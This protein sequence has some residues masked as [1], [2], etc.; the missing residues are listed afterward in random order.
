MVIMAVLQNLILS[1]IAAVAFGIMFNVPTHCLKYCAILGASACF[2]RTILFYLGA[3]AWL[4]TFFPA[5]LVGILAI[6]FSEKFKAHPKVVSVAAVI[7]MFPGVSA[8]TAMIALIEIIDTGYTP[9]LMAK[10]VTHFLHASS[11]VCALSL[12]LTLPSIWMYRKRAR[13]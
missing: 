11:I 2:L 10:L 5:M 4:V 8:Y 9:E 1:A 12:G 6:K 13:V 3:G 7:P